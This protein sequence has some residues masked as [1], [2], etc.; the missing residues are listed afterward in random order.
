MDYEITVRVSAEEKVFDIP[1]EDIKNDFVDFILKHVPPED[2]LLFTKAFNIVESRMR[3][4][5]LDLCKK[6]LIQ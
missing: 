2:Q 3:C 5:F 4:V 1:W 6:S